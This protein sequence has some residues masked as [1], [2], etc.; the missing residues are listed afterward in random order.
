MAPSFSSEQSNLNQILTKMFNRGVK[1]S[2]LADVLTG[3]A[4]EYWPDIEG[5]E[6]REAVTDFGLRERTFFD[7]ALVHLL[8]TATLDRLREL[9][10][11]GRFEVRRFRPNIVVEVAGGEKDWWRTHGSGTRSQSAMPFV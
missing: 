5:L 8:T 9:C 7:C 10:P 4:E 1:F 11:Q 3:T 2:A 6:H